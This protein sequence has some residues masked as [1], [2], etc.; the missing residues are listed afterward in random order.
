MF[1]FKPIFSIFISAFLLASLSAVAQRIYAPNSVLSTGNWYKISVN[2]AGIYKIDIPFLNKLGINTSSLSSSSIK[3]YGNGGGLLTELTTGKKLDDLFENAIWVED[4]G[5]GVLNGADYI[6]FYAEGPHEWR[7]DTIQKTFRHEKNIYSEQSF[8]FIQVGADGKRIKDQPATL[9]PTTT[10]TSFNSRYFHELDTLNFL[11]S[12]KE[13]YGEEFSTMAGKQLNRTFSFLVPGITN[14]PATFISNTIARSFGTGSKFNITINTQPILQVDI[15]PVS[16]G[17]FDL[18]AQ[19]I[20]SSATFSSTSNT[21]AVNYSY[22]EGSFSSQGWLN[23][24][25][26]H[27]HS[28]LSM[29]GVD[30][31]VFRDWNSVGLGKTGQFIINNAAVNTQVWDISNRLNP[32]LMKTT[33][34]GNNLQFVNDCSTLHEYIAFNTANF[35]LPVGIG[36][37]NNQDLH[38]SGVADY[39]IITDAT[40]LGQA[41]RLAQYHQQREGLKT[42]VVSSEQVF[43]EF[44]SGTPD[45]TALRDFVKM[46]FDKAGSDTAKRPK[47]LLL[48]GDASFDYKNRLRNNTNLVPAYESNSSLDP[49]STYTSDDF[50]GLLSDGDD[51]NGNGVYLLDIGVGRIPANSEVAARSIVDKIISYN[52]STGLGPWRNE[53]TFIADDED[54]NLHLQDAEI[55]TGAA[56]ATAPVFN[57]DKI[58]LDSYKQEGGS[59]GSRYPEVNNAI[60]SK[61]FNGTLI[62]NYSGHGGFRRL[63]EEVVLD[64]EI[65]NQ[66]NNPTKLPLFI[67]ATCDVAPFDN[68]LIN[69]IGENLLLREKTGAIALMTTTRLVF[70]F[71]NRL[72]NKNYLEAA[73]LRK[74]DGSYP[75]LGEAVKRAKNFT[76]TFSTDIVN[77]RKFTLLGDPALTIGFPIYQVKTTTIN[78][79]SVGTTPDTLKALSTYNIEGEILDQF[80][81][82]VTN[83]NGTVFPVVF[84]KIQNQT[85]LAND[86]G[87]IVANYPVQ[88]NL[89][90]RGKAKAENGKFKF[91]FIVPK[92]IDYKFGNGKISYYT[93]NGS[94]DGNGILTN[95]IVG[96]TGVGISDDEG[97][98]LKG[99]LNDEKFVNGSITGNTP[100]LVV[101]LFDSSGINIMG[102]GIGHDLTAMLDRDP[103]KIFILNQFYEADLDNF[104]RGIVRFQLPQLEEGLH[105]LT[106]KAWDVA[107]N[108]SEITIE[109][110]IIKPE[111]FTINHVLNYPNPFTS[112]TTFWFEHNR[113]G[114]ELN[115]FVQVYT[116]AGRLVKTLRKTIFAVGNRSCEV[117]W[118]GRDEYGSKIGRGV[119]IYRLKVQSPDGKSAEKWEKIFIL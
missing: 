105:T 67:T 17:S 13:W 2:N 76:Y 31:L 80:G 24:F 85:T 90:F 110:N 78:T 83:F 58:Y 33:L 44:S 69:S 1:F 32:I 39:I 52:S 74:P 100:V 14:Q 50:F 65:I 10:I 117:D 27:A 99:F 57:N 119:Y 62:W 35:L 92:D 91:S 75:S 115:V 56:M 5:D 34:A 11:S 45:P 66:L 88:K 107:N 53:L 70:A 86:P 54:G 60:N 43:N 112:H 73:L 20:L 111:S 59:G 23:W 72:M 40:F 68:P 61:L 22:S 47:Y 16:N 87:S 97:P 18:F 7:I 12:G 25:E 55:I 114:E 98:A 113:A 3:L 63:A 95:I 21:L 81:N 51:I 109:F 9:I 82:T 37:I 103:Q 118:D 102:T 28:N 36:K 77:N 41:Q 64:Q 89:L 19:S 116:V 96:G 104:R 108:S 30:Q 49:L 29:S 101:K 94:I 15:P 84:D 8:Y 71:S 79:R 4:G 106:I 38:K 48:F 46:Y 93:D 26:V 42:V 6:L